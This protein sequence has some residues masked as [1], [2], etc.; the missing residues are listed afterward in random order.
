MAVRYRGLAVYSVLLAALTA[1]WLAHD[2]AAAPDFPAA[3]VVALCIAASLTVFHF[4][5]PAPRVGLASMERLPQIGLLLVLDPA[6]AATICG[7]ASLVWPLINRRY[8]QGSPRVAVLRGVH[9]AAMTALMLLLAG[10]AYLALGGEH[11]LTGIG[12]PDLLPLVAMALVAQGVNVALLALYFRLDRRDVRRLIKPIY[13]LI[14]LMFVPAGVLAAVLFNTAA[15]PV[16]TLFVVLMAI[17]V[18]SFN[19]LHRAPGGR[20]MSQRP[21]VNLAA[22]RTSLFGA[23]RLDELASRIRTEIAALFRFD[24]LT[25]CLVD[26]EAGVP[27]VRLHEKDGRRSSGGECPLPAGL[28]R[29]IVERQEAVLIEDWALAPEPLRREADA[30]ERDSGSLIAVPLIEDGTVIGVLSVSHARAGTWSDAD[31]HLLRQVAGQVSAAV[32]DARAFED[33]ESYRKDLEKRVAERTAELERANSE[34]ER[35]IAALRER[36]RVLERETQEDPLTGIAN[37]RHF[38]QRLE[39]EVRV[40]ASVG[41]PLTLA[42]ADLDDFK[43]IND[44]LGHAVGDEVLRQ[45]AKLMRTLCRSTDLVARIGGEEFA[46]ILPGMSR[47]AALVFCEAVRR[48][49][50]AHDWTRINPNLRVT[51]SIGLYQWDGAGATAELLREADGRLYSAKRAGRNRVA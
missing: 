18:L 43:V 28:F 22:T 13:S 11:P 9:N 38:A 23:R 44:R 45:C 36:S 21:L 5:V 20:S 50:E 16:F 19:R 33:L 37:R 32:A 39:D 42:V 25:L 12:M 2:L 27:D 26:A 41:Q 40:A 48:A 3:W 6:I 15:P 4:G 35:L 1:A 17:F 8:S 51:L 10:D 34:K 49:V 31:L 30:T 47:D 24:E 29:W 7:A 14:D 46:L